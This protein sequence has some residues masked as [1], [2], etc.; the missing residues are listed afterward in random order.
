MSGYGQHREAVANALQRAFPSREDLDEL[1]SYDLDLNIEELPGSISATASLP[2]LVLS[3]IKWA[4]KNGFERKL[5]TAARGRNPDNPTLEGVAKMV[6][7]YLDESSPL[8]WYEPP[9]PV[10]TCLIGTDKALV[11][12]VDLRD[13]VRELMVS[14][15]PRT[16]VVR[17]GPGSGRSYSREFISFVEGKSRAFNV[18]YV[19]LSNPGLTPLQLLRKIAI[20]TGLLER[21][22]VLD[23][24]QQD[25]QAMREN[26]DL[27]AWLF[28]ELKDSEKPWWLIIDG[29]D[30]VGLPADTYD[31]MMK[32]VQEAEMNEPLRVILLACSEPLPP[33]VQR[34]RV[35]EIKTI[36][37]DVLRGFF[38]D[39]LTHQGRGATDE[40]VDQAVKEVHR[41]VG[42]EP[43]NPD[44][45]TNL[46]A[47]AALAAKTL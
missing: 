6:L 9:H 13:Y 30:Q 21:I 40:A 22:K 11:D 20:R 1:T 33:R 41:I 31:L 7:A 2:A 29:I 27:C 36:T 44:W 46:S 4:E 24:E 19:P 3:L 25:E 39:F 18:A 47:A 23:N 37:D 34:V 12:R 42:V 17:G 28:T 8:P 14:E 43:D 15:G 38:R 35:E 45:L 32:I 10:R 26:D 16:L 5:V